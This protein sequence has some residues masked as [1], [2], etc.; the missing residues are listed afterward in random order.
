LAFSK[1]QSE[2]IDVEAKFKSFDFDEPINYSPS[3]SSGITSPRIRSDNLPAPPTVRPTSPTT[4]A[5]LRDP[6]TLVVTS[7]SPVPNKAPKTVPNTKALVVVKP[8]KL[9]FV[10]RLAPD[11][12]IEDVKTY[13][14]SKISVTNVV[15]E[16]FKFNYS[17]DIASFKIS[18]PADNFQSVCS[19]TFWPPDLIVKEYSPK[20]KSRTAVS[21]PT[22]APSSSSS[23]TSKNQ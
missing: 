1:L 12:S 6:P 10:S 5:N 9:V 7:P 11:T 16:K 8:K 13:I 17:R 18:I 19:G 14:Q 2:F 3:T 22:A 4:P 15:V 20:Q 21:L 23:G